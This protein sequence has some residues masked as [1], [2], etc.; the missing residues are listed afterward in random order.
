MSIPSNDLVETLLS[1]I[2]QALD[3]LG[4]TPEK[5]AILAKG[6]LRSKTTRT[7][8]IKG[9][10]NG[11]KLP[12]GFKKVTDSGLIENDGEKGKFFGT[13][14]T[15]I[16]VSEVNW[17]IRQKARMDMHKLRGDYP[18]EKHDVKL[19]GETLDAILNALPEDFRA[20]V[21]ANLKASRS[22]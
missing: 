11:D 2:R 15:L 20:A 17:P 4:I 1:P 7:V 5:L 10:I 9:A 13:G 21:I 22:K 12:N 18:A 3:N 14:E 19:N 8:K 16:E 6:E